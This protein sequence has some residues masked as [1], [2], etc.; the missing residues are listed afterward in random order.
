MTK[1]TLLESQKSAIYQNL[2]SINRRAQLFTRSIA[3]NIQNPSMSPNLE[4]SSNSFVMS[5]S[6][7]VREKLDDLNKA[8]ELINVLGSE[9]RKYLEDH[10][11]LHK[12]IEEAEEEHMWLQE[13]FQIVKSAE[14]GNDLSSTQILINKHEQLEDELKFRK[15]RI[16]DKISAKGEQLISSMTYNTPENEKIAY[17][18]SS[19]LALF[20]TLKKETANRR[21]ILED[22]F[23]SQ[24]YFADAN[25]ADS[26]MKDKMALVSLNSYTGKDEASSQALLHRHAR[27]QEEI[28]AYEPE[29][30]RLDEIT[31]V[32][33]GKRRFSSFPVNM[34]QKLMKN[35][36][37]V[38]SSEQEDFTEN[39]DNDDNDDTML[40]NDTDL[41]SM[42]EDSALDKSNSIGKLL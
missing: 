26:W 11:E 34:R 1:H 23:T 33:V 13:K 39:D 3:Q 12:F 35:N 28:K 36:T 6:E 41:D 14:T 16:D 4:S 37:N 21:S 17:K 27:I 20:E 18:C 42:Q 29:I 10:R 15:Q 8:F 9:R 30:R 40:N 19:L 38:N 5:E 31:N 25:E 22:S 32:L 7:L 2:K 24:Q